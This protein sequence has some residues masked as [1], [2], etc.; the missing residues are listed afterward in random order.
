MTQRRLPTASPLRGRNL[1][2]ASGLPAAR[3]F[4]PVARLLGRRID[5]GVGPGEYQ[6]GVAVLE[7]HDVGWLAA[8][9]SYLHDLAYVVRLAH[10]VAMYVE[11]VSDGCV[12]LG[13][14]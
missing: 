12:H 1:R 13:T 11:L 2:S 4:L 9:S 14:S 8:S 7:A 6:A 10:H 3:V 5:D